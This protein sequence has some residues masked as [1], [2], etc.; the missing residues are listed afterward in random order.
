MP[1]YCVRKPFTVLVGVVM[2]IVLGVV[3]FTKITTDLL[4]SISF[5]YVMAVTTYPGASPEKVEDSVTE[6]V[7][8]S[9]GKVNK[10]KTVSSVSSENTS[11]VMLEFEEDTDMDGAMVKLSTACEKVKEALPEDAG[12]P[13]LMEISPDMMATMTVGVDY[14]GKDIKELS[15]FVENELMPQLEREEGVAGADAIGSAIEKVEIRINGS[16]VDELNDRLLAKTDGKFAEA[17][18]TLDAKESELNGATE[19]LS[20]KESQLSA[21]ENETFGEMAEL[22]QHTA[23]DGTARRRTGWTRA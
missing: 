22:S 1:K 13:M 9:L 6:V 7:E 2:I 8:R 17:R 11:M 15:R 20:G 3:S 10:V 19:A 18:K 4:P 5:P 12:A 23:A 14:E 16:K 21:K